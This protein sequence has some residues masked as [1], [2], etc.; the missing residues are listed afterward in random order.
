MKIESERDVTREER[1]RLLCYFSFLLQRMTL[2]RQSSELSAP[3]TN[4][5]KSPIYRL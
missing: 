4:E 3:P 5:S 1:R 2:G